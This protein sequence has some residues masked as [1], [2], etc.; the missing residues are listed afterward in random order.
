MDIIDHII[1]KISEF[2]QDVAVNCDQADGLY[3]EAHDSYMVFSDDGRR[4]KC[5]CIE[6]AHHIIQK[7]RRNDRDRMERLH[8]EGFDI[9]PHRERFH[10][11]DN[12]LREVH[13]TK[14]MFLLMALQKAEKKLC[15]KG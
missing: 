6:E 7:M 12:S 13:A 4:Y 10:W 14:L 11:N 1:D 5:G 9:H 8:R 3:T 15:K 2:G